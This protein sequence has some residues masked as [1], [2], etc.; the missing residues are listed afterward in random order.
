MCSVRLY[1]LI[2]L[3]ALSSFS[4]QA[5]T[6]QVLDSLGQVLIKKQKFKE[7]DS[8]LKLALKKIEIQHGKDTAYSIVA[9]RLGKLYYGNLSRYQEA[10]PILEE[11]HRLLSQH[12]T[13]KIL[14]YALACHELANLYSELDRFEEAERYY[15]ESKGIRERVLGKMS[16]EYAISCNN[17]ANLYMDLGNHIQ[18]EQLHEEARSIREAVLGKKHAHYAS[19]CNNLALLNQKIGKY[20][21]AEAYYIE[22]RHIREEVYGKKHLEYAAACSNLANLY[23]QEGIYERATALHTEA[24]QIKADLLGEDNMSY[25]RTAIGLAITYS[26]TGDYRKAEDCMIKCQNIIAQKFGKEHHEFT[27]V[28]T[29]LA[30]N[31]FREGNYEKAKE[32]SLMAL[33]TTQKILGREQ[34]ETAQLLGNLSSMYANLHLF[35]SAIIYGE[36][37]RQ[38]KIKLF[39]NKHIS[40]I[41]E[42]ISLANIY[43]NTKNQ[44]MAHSLFQESF[45]N[46]TEYISN[47][48]PNLSEQEKQAFWHSFQFFLPSYTDL[49]SQDA[50][51]N[52][53]L[54]AFV[55]NGILFTKGI[56]FS[57]TQ[58][59][60]NAI[61]HSG[62]TAL[63]NQFKDWKKKRELHTHL[64]QLSLNE[65]KQQNINLEELKIQVNDLEKDLSQKSTNFGENLQTR[66]Y[67]WQ[68]VKAKLAKNEVVVEVIKTASNYMALFV[69]PNTVSAPNFLTFSN[70][71]LMETD[72][73]S[74]YKNCIEFK[75]DD[76][77]SYSAFWQP[78]AEKIKTL[79]IKK[80]AK[81]YFAPDGVFHQISLNTL[82]NPKT[83][84]FL[85]DESKI[86]L[87]GSSRDVIELNKKSRDLSKN[88][89][90]YQAHLLGYPV[91]GINKAEKEQEKKRDRS[92]GFSGIQSA[93]G[94]AGSVS[95]L[96]GTKKEVEN[97]FGLFNQKKLKVN[98][99]LAENA[100]EEAVK[101]LKSPTVLHVAT[102][103]FFIPEVKDA[104]VKDI[105][106]AMNRNLLKNP[107]MRSGLLLAGC[108]KPN[109]EGEDG[110]LTA[111]EV[112]NLNL[113]DTELVVMSACET[114]LGDIEAGEGVFGLQRAFQ[115]AGAKSILMSLWKV[116]DE[117]TQTLMTEFYTALLK[118]QSKRQAFKTAQMTLKKRFPE[119][120]YWGAFV[121]LGE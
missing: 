72:L 54:M 13:Q 15:T 38:I 37:A 11:A 88:Y 16:V 18:A 107:L 7:A 121:L 33:Q 47:I 50:G 78:I 86:Q 45:Q 87:I 108:Q 2:S 39:G 41:L 59:M 24:L 27:S 42:G 4:T 56:I 49:C 64:Q 75:V 68:D 113:D 100:T 73:L 90:N 66:S 8:V 21:I 85:L 82:K 103:G 30:N 92:A 46:L 12:K 35:D 74:Y 9:I 120:Y 58:K 6:W 17:L 95:M 31:Y 94:V 70:P 112:M 104:E 77:V 61:L 19:S 98:L 119:P 116:D 5:Q 105:Q 111:E 84:L 115:Q 28:C 44:K 26:H 60:K 79:G 89:Q 63:I 22:T 99:L 51:S 29:N 20:N 62:D 71:E 109:P 10:I 1:L 34:L 57:S 102:H 32:L 55:F 67:K 65:Q 40:T 36:E 118:G 97:V 14:P 76:T 43:Q 91:Y 69:T 53:E 25:V 114:G 81:I 117:A 83:G 23:M 110:I 106:M 96:P 93:V 3:L 80:N 101:N 52:P 48:F